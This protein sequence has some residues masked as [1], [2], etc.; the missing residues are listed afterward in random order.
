MMQ[1]PILINLPDYLLHLDLLQLTDIPRWEIGPLP[2]VVEVVPVGVGQ[3]VGM[4][5]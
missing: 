5:Q 2:T 1:I 4:G 3:R